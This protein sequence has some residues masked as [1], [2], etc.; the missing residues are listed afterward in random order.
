MKNYLILILSLLFVA[1][2]LSA[3][4]T[5]NYE[6]EEYSYGLM[7][8]PQIP[9]GVKTPDSISRTQ[10]PFGAVYGAYFRYNFYK[11]KTFVRVE[12]MRTGYKL[13]LKNENDEK[14]EFDAQCFE[15][16]ALAGGY[17]GPKRS[18]FSFFGGAT[19]NIPLKAKFK[20]S[21]SVFTITSKNETFFVPQ[22]KVGVAYDRAP[23][24]ITFS[25]KHDLAT[26]SAVSLV[27][28]YTFTDSE[29]GPYRLTFIE[30]TFGIFL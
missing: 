17:F 9:I 26:R 3:Q 11:I 23:M 24:S 22:L 19:L 2:S 15:L 13:R 25:I 30:F 8:G 10:S 20:P 21:N 14:L 18:N 4:L 1:S 5:R 6:I 12:A 7:I 16:A 27:N 29:R 28:P